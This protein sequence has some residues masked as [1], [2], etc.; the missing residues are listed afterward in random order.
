MTDAP[1]PPDRSVATGPGHSLTEPAPA[2]CT[3]HPHGG[4]ARRRGPRRPPVTA[5]VLTVLGLAVAGCAAVGLAAAPARA[6]SAPHLVSGWPG[7][8]SRVSSP[9][10]APSGSASGTT[11][12]A[13]AGGPSTSS[14]GG[15]GD[16]GFP[17]PPPLVLTAFAAALLGSAVHR[18]WVFRSNRRALRNVARATTDP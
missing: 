3:P 10:P 9:S 4:T 14:S 5:A 11:V 17:W 12:P 15:S 13:A 18:W 16:E 8:G 2:G 6:T 7:N 1:S